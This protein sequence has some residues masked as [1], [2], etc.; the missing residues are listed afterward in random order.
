MARNLQMGMSG[1]HAG[2]VPTSP[3]IPLAAPHGRP[4]QPQGPTQ[5]TR[6]WGGAL[7]LSPSGAVSPRLIP[8]HGRDSVAPQQNETSWDFGT[9]EPGAVPGAT[10]QRRSSSQS[11]S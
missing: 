7:V 10:S 4:A 5:G 9:K 8:I 2:W 6:P 1:H 11:P 3:S